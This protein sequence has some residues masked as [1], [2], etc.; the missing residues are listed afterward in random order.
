MKPYVA[1]MNYSYM[2]FTISINP[3]GDES[4]SLQEQCLDIAGRCALSCADRCVLVLHEGSTASARQVEEARTSGS[5]RCWGKVWKTQGNPR[6]NHGKCGK[7]LEN[8][9]LIGN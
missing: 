6:K 5:H 7:M 9:G 1:N 8:D 2:T 4:T 3:Y